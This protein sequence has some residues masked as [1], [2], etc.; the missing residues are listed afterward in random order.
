M[1]LRR[2][3]AGAT[4]LSVAAVAVAVGVVGYVSTRSH[5]LGE[6]KSE[7]RARAAPFLRKHPAGQARLL[8]FSTG[9]RGQLPSAGHGV[10]VPPGPALGGAPGYFQFVYPDGRIVARTGG[11]PELRADA[12]VLAIARRGSGSFFTAAKV[13]G[14]HAE[15]LTVADKS[16]GAAVQI[17]LPLTGVDSVLDGLLL[18][19][20]L[21]VGG[22][23]LLG[24]LLG[25]AISRS[26]LAPIERFVRRTESVN[27][28]QDHPLRL[29]EGGAS[30]L[31]RLAASFNRTLDAL[32]RSIE[33]QRGLVADA[34]HEL[35]TP[36]AALRSNI[37]IFLEADRLPPVERVSL[38]RSIIDE[39]DELT[40]VVA[41]VMELARGAARSAGREPVELDVLVQEAVGRARRRAPE[42]H[43]DVELQP[44]VI[45]GA[46]EQVA[47]AVGNVIDNACKWSP[48]GG[49]VEVRLRDGALSVR[50]HGPGFREQ[51]LE[52]VFDRFY[53]ADDARRMPG[54]G[55]GLAIVKQATDAHH[56]EARAMNAP[57][58]GA[59]V[60]V[61]F[62]APVSVGPVGG[63]PDG[64]RQ[65]PS[66]G[67]ARV[68]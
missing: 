63:E 44:T 3:I 22:G 41:D 47:R 45:D 16:R 68:G 10:A 17:A 31:R 62:G 40:E 26:A 53:R 54:S 19:Y 13:R 67:S 24:L 56:G 18:P 2:R 43:F 14:I 11:T 46:P 29:E 33:A 37:Q 7:L 38:Q 28:E 21:L 60:E 66:P 27:V 32:E 57:G 36:I 34:S 64:A 30:E 5:L 25:A 55:L 50:D 15:V 39:L 8:P 58:G 65:R 1:S 23:V 4:A 35:R 52:R 49:A 59:L 61:S 48:A 42:I 51:D 12:R 20:G 6:T 9:G